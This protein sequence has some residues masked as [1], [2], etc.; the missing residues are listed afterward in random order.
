MVS[1]NCFVIR[2]FEKSKLGYFKV[3]NEADYKIPI[4]E[5]ENITEYAVFQ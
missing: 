5:I 2:F 4:K 3:I 1:V